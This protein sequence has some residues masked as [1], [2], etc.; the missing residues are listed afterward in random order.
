MYCAEC[1]ES[2]RGK[3]CSNC[4]TRTVESAEE[5][6]LADVVDGWAHEVR[7]D[8]L[9]KFPA[10]RATIEQHERQAPKRLSGEQFLA[11]ADKLMPQ[12]VPLEG[13]AAVTQIVLTRLGVKTD[14]RREEHVA[15]PVGEVI[16]RIL[17]S[18][19][20]NGQKIRGVTQAA[21]GCVIEAVQPSDVWS[22]EGTLLITV[23][24]QADNVAESEVSVTATVTGQV[25]DW[26]KNR[27]SIDGLFGDVVRRAA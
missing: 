25:F 26:G 14:K 10:V 2:V 5:L 22:L 20:R 7:Y 4:G 11:L 9:L 6:T 12:P 19:A 8:N 18:L 27:R 21:D 13:L 24:R 3:F 16:V 15:A 1:G 17:C 23:R